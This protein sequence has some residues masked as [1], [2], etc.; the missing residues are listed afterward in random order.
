MFTLIVILAVF[1]VLAFTVAVINGLIAISPIL[2]LLVMLPIV[3][4]FVIRT[5]CKRVFK[6]KEKK[7]E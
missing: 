4:Y 7:E 3:D 1:M 6:K 5:I 2:L